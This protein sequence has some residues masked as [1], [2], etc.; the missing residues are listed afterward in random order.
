MAKGKSKT[1][2]PAPSL[3]EILGGV[4]PSS[5]KVTLEDVEAGR[6]PSLE[7]LQQ[8]AARYH[9]KRNGKQK[10]EPESAKPYRQQFT[11]APEEKPVDFDELM[12]RAQVLV[13]KT[14]VKVPRPYAITLDAAKPIYF[15]LLKARLNKSI[16]I[17][18]NMKGV[19]NQLLAYFCGHPCPA[20]QVDG[21]EIPELNLGKGI[22]L[23][24]AVG[25][26]KS[27]IMEAFSDFSK[28]LQFRK[29]EVFSVDQ[30]AMELQSEKDVQM[31]LEKQSGGWL[32][33]D[34]FLDQ[35]TNVWGNKV[36][37]SRKIIDGY[38][39]K[40]FPAGRLIHC[41]S[42]IA[43]DKIGNQVND[44]RFT[45]RMNEVFNYVFIKGSNKRNG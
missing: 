12:G 35:E 33:D 14:R 28:V 42:N 4:D 13:A 29:F 43:P 5:V 32:A 24:G 27:K 8:S 31:I 16:V 17:D 36:D 1:E 34:M 39:R 3:A 19:I 30:M 25:V 37:V 38:Y 40:G 11:V 7:D 2:T 18:G 23:W 9:E 10:H 6:L 41:T 45:S 20:R 15:K 44:L 26:G 22:Y 21:H